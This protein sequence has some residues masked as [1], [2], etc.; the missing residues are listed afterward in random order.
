MDQLPPPRIQ[1]EK[2]FTE[3]GAAFAGPVIIKGSRG[4]GIK[5]TKRILWFSC[6]WRLLIRTP[7]NRACQNFIRE[8]IQDDGANEISFLAAMKLR[9]S[10]PFDCNGL[11]LEKTCYD[12]SRSQRLPTSQTPLR[13]EWPPQ[14]ASG[15]PQPN[16]SHLPLQI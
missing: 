4:R 2:S 7:P 6:A 10:K 5:T 9:I 12:E 8:T 11:F 14:S 13:G 16:F 1:L 15:P 3:T